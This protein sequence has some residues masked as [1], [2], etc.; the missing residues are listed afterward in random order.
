MEYWTCFACGDGS[1]FSNREAFVQHTETFH[2]ETVP[3]AHIPVLVEL[4]KKTLP[5]EIPHCPLCNWPEDDEVEVEKDALFNH[6]AKEVHSFSLRALPWADDNGQESNRRIHNSSEKVYDWLIKN[7]IQA[8]PGGER[9][10]REE[11]LCY[12]VYFQENAYFACSSEE[13]SSTELDSDESRQ[14]ELD[15]LRRVNEIVSSGQKSEANA[16][17]ALHSSTSNPQG[18]DGERVEELEMPMESRGIKLSEEHSDTK[19][20]PLDA[21]SDIFVQNE[22]DLPSAPAYFWG[23]SA[24]T[25]TRTAA[26]IYFDTKADDNFMSH[27]FAK[28]LD[29]P[30]EPSKYALVPTFSDEAPQTRLAIKF[31][32]QVYWRFARHDRVYLTSFLVLDTEADKYGAVLGRGSIFAFRLFQF[33]PLNPVSDMPFEQGPVKEDI[34]DQD[35][36]ERPAKLRSL[37]ARLRSLFERKPG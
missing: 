35:L 16:N 13:S 18:D 10:L 27:K 3:L 4:S 30:L 26:L 25:D 14:N 34:E 22:E 2:A 29:V 15:E 31:E 5:S 11:R 24:D 28:E 6:I 33:P 32:I 19:H 7:V 36:L 21:S 37:G 23:R 17:P 1:Q 12:D 9:P 8:Y 20:T